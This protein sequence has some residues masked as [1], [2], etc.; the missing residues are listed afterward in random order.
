MTLSELRAHQ[1]EVMNKVHTEPV[2]IT[3]RGKTPRAVLVSPEFFEAALEALEDQEDL[4]A[5]QA[6]R[7]EGVYVNFADAMKALGID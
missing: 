1:S 4:R 7:D 5:A 2:R 3:S 6:A